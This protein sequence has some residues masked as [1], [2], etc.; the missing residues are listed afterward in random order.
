VRFTQFKSLKERVPKY[1]V[2]GRCA[3]TQLQ[4]E[5]EPYTPENFHDKFEDEPTDMQHLRPD[6]S[7]SI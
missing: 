2:M 4:L 5:A 6:S 7:T 3:G 1:Y